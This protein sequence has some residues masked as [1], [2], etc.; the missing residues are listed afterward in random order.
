MYMYST[1]P[2]ISFFRLPLPPSPSPSP[3]PLIPPRNRLR[4]QKLL[5]PLRGIKPPKATLLD[6]P[7]RQPG[8][9]MNRH[10]IHMHSPALDLPRDRQAPAQI[11]REDRARE[12]VLGVVRQ[13]DGLGVAVD[14]EERDR[15]AEGLGVVEVHGLGH[16]RDDERPHARAGSRRGVVVEGADGE[17]GAFGER[18][19]DEGVVLFDAGGGDEDGG[20]AGGGEDGGDGGGEVGGEGGRDGGVHD[21]ALGGHADLAALGR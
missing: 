1:I 19:G 5:K 9:I 12:A 2:T 21:D 14:D 3:R 8:L 17:P 20:G 10:T 11:L 7:M 16:V 4:P 13:R 15:R 6:P 18:V